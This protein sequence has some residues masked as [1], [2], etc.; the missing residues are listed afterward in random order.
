MPSIHANKPAELDVPGSDAA[1][2]TS[3]RETLATLAQISGMGLW[4]GTVPSMATADEKANGTEVLPD[5]RVMAR[6]ESAVD[7]ALEYLIRHQQDDG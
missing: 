6:V 5:P 4:L 1:K 3:R 7:Q 2:H